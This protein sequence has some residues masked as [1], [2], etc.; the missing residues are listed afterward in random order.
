MVVSSHY[1]K[2]AM[3]QPLTSTSVPQDDSASL[4]RSKSSNSYNMYSYTPGPDSI[5]GLPNKYDEVDTSFLLKMQPG[6]LASPEPKP[7]MPG[8]VPM[9]KNKEINILSFKFFYTE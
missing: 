9:S 7:A 5:N 2:P 1:Y 3:L 6:A 4:E 8:S